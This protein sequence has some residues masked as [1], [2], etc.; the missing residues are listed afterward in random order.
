MGLDMPLGDNQENEGWVKVYRRGL[1]ALTLSK[2]KM[3]HLIIFI[4]V[5]VQRKDS[6]TPLTSQQTHLQFR[7]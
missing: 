4:R 7:K 2:T 1:S 6:A 3:V 5:N